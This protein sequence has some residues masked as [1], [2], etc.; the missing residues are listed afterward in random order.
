MLTTSSILILLAAGVG[1][2]FMSA[3][4][5][6]GGGAVMVPVSYWLILGMDVAPDIAIRTALGT[7]LLVILPTVIS[8]S[9]RHN[10]EKAVRW[11]TA[12]IL[13]SS[14]LVGGLVGASLAAHLPEGILKAGFG[15]VILAI[16]LWMGLGILPKLRRE[17]AEPRENFALVAACGFPIGV[18]SGLTG[19]GGGVLIVALLVLALNFPVHTAVGTSV[20]AIILGSLGGIVGYIVNGLGVP[21]LLPYSI[22]YVNLPIWLCLAATSIPMAQLGGRAAHALPA[23]PLMYIFIAFMVYAGLDMIGVFHWI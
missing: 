5:G 20:A 1:T 19:I 22:G 11:K 16:A 15:G 23:K 9:W 12:L 17:D 18:V 6:I 2:G 13:G 10:K 7:S 14:A 3:L 21:G 4:L 8:G